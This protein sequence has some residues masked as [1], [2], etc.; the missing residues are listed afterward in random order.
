MKRKK[1]FM[2]LLMLAFINLIFVYCAGEVYAAQSE[3]KLEIIG[4]DE[5]YDLS[6]ISG[7]PVYIAKVFY[8]GKLLKGEELKSVDLKWNPEESIVE[9]KKEYRSSHMELSLHNKDEEKSDALKYGIYSVKIHAFYVPDGENEKTTTAEL[10]YIIEDGSMSTD[11]TSTSEK[12]N[13]NDSYSQSVKHIILLSCLGT[14]LLVVFYF[15]FKLLGM[16]LKSYFGLISD[17]EVNGF[18]YVSKDDVTNDAKITA[19]RAGNTLSMEVMY[20]DIIT[21]IE[22]DLKGEVIRKIMPYIF[23]RNIMVDPQSVYVIGNANVEVANVGGA[24]FS[25]NEKTKVLQP[26]ITC[27]E[28]SEFTDELGIKIFGTMLLNGIE[29]PFIA[30]TW[31]VV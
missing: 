19:E 30:E 1:C 15:V 14:F 17:I 5:K 8:N 29:E 31:L 7:G 27:I 10:T 9:I 25:L 3:L 20:K 11:K 16:L 22:I 6:D 21:G 23:R 28:N 24:I 12:N 13:S 26:E 2:M 4:G 18:L